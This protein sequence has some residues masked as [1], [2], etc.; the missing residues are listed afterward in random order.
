M[1][2]LTQRRNGRHF[3]VAPEAIQST[4][5]FVTKERAR[6]EDG[7]LTTDM[8]ET[9]SS[10]VSYDGDGGDGVEIKESEL[11]VARLR[12]AWELRHHARELRGE[13]PMAVGMK[14]YPQGAGIEFICCQITKRLR[15]EK[16]AERK[17]RP[18]LWSKIVLAFTGPQIPASRRPG[19]RR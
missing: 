4:G 18:T 13:L 19:D 3:Y 11:D 2:R 9:V 12:A 16:A 8:I 6:D 5:E 14:D 10:Y 15:E 1:I 7:V 17:M